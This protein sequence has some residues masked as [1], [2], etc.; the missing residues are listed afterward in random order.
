MCQLTRRQRHCSSS[1]VSLAPSFFF[2]FLFRYFTERFV[3]SAVFSWP[4]EIFFTSARG[5]RDHFAEP[6]LS[7]PG[8][9]TLK[10]RKEKNPRTSPTRAIWNA[11]NC[12]S[13]CL[14]VDFSSRSQ[15]KRRD[16][17]RC[18]RTPRR[19]TFSATFPGKKGEKGGWGKD[20]REFPWRF[21]PRERK[22]PPAE[23]HG[24]SLPRQSD[25]VGASV[26]KAGP[27][28][29]PCDFY[30]VTGKFPVPLP[31]PFSPPSSSC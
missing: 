23:I 21:L 2:F 24:S 11:A 19:D 15:V 9:L 1:S 12:L 8:R 4:L 6:S 29:P 5:L 26:G 13:V 18:C 3:I 10:R 14:S 20:E 16:A 28:D 7:C 31:S 30:L 22:R 25:D 27:G 17:T